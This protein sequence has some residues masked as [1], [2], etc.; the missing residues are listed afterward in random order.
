[1]KKHYIT[2]VKFNLI[3]YG[4]TKAEIVWEYGTLLI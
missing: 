4:N 1:M 2:H 3:Q